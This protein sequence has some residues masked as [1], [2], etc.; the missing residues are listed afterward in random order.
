MKNVELFIQVTDSA[1]MEPLMFT[2]QGDLKKD[3]LDCIMG[4]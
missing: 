4:N 2:A 1:Q 3:V